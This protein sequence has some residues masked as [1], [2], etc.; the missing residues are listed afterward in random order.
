MVKQVLPYTS[1]DAQDIAPQD[2]LDAVNGLDVRRLTS[3]Q[4]KNL[5]QKRPLAMLFSTGASNNNGGGYGRLLPTKAV[6]KF[7]RALLDRSPCKRCTATEALQSPCLHS[8]EVIPCAPVFHE[9]LQ[10]SSQLPSEGSPCTPLFHQE[11]KFGIQ[12]SD[13]FSTI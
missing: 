9:A 6:E 11:V 3:N 5:M 10:S 7:A 12:L 1:A 4:F 8:S 2:M 13:N